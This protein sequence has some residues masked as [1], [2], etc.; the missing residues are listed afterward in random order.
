[1]VTYLEI[2]G[3]GDGEVP[4]SWSTFGNKLLNCRS[5]VD[6]FQNPP[7]KLYGV[8]FVWFRTRPLRGRDVSE[9]IVVVWL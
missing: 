8:F 6:T 2:L 7:P 3:P 9:V 4:V 5:F 1:M